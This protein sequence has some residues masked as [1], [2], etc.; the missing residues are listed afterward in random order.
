[1]ED[2]QKSIAL[3]HTLRD[4]GTPLSIDDFGTGYSSLA[5]LQ[6][7]PV[8]ELKIDRAFI[9]KIDSLPGSQKLVKAM[10]EMGHSMDLMVTAEGVETEAERAVVA[11]L[12]CDV[13]QGYLASKPLHGA[14]LQSWFDK[15]PAHT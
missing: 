12:G 15:L 3:L 13:M 11:Q 9:D 6:K 4:L 14:A 5:Y 2:A 7:M 10:I 1:M 8:S